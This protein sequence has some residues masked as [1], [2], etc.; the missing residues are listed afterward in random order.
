MSPKPE[1]RMRR[2]M[3]PTVQAG[4]SPPSRCKRRSLGVAQALDDRAH[5]IREWPF[6]QR[7]TRILG[8]MVAAVASTIIGRF[9]S[10]VL[11]A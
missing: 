3:S 7:L 5:Q 4:H 10:L 1:P 11:F 6:D 2:P 9:V 8:F